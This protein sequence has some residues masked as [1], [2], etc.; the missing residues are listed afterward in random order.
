[1]TQVTTQ[2]E[3]LGELVERVSE[4]VSARL[5]SRLQ[6]YDPTW[7]MT[8]LKRAADEGWLLT[9]AE[10]RQLIGVKPKTSKGEKVYFPGLLA[11]SK[12]RKDRLTNCLESQ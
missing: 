9:T 11:I 8:V 2:A 4:K 1:M 12:S 7:Y 10:V 5:I 3:L 6:P